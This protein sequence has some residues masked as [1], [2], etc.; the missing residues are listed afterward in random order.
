MSRS[1]EADLVFS[2]FLFLFL[3]SFQFIFLYSIFR[4][5]IRV[6]VTIYAVT[7]HVTSDDMVTSHM[8]HRRT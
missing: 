8:M 1:Q 6:R 2:Y 4:T 3:F 7:Q 5:R